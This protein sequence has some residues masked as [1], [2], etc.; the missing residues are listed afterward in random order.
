MVGLLNKAMYGLRDAPQVWQQE[1]R[2]IMSELD[3][4]ESKT[5]PCVYFNA[6][7]GVRVVTHVD[8]F[9]CVGP[10]I[11]LQ[12]FYSE[13]DKV[14]DLKCEILGPGPGEGKEGQFLGRQ[15]RWNDWGLSWR[16]DNK[17][18]GEML[19][20]WGMEEC[21]IVGT[22]CSK[23]EGAKPREEGDVVMEDQGRITR[24]RRAAAK[25]NY[26]ALDDPRI[27]YASKCISQCMAKPTEEG[28]GRLKRV[29]RYLSGSPGCEWKFEWQ[30]RPTHLV[31]YTDSDWAGCPRTRRSTSGGG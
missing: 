24:F 21:S 20:E 14:L 17:L 10:K 4:C 2:R 18:L 16:G 3:F 9:L 27:S 19:K 6:R 26:M 31:G 12:H 8:D 1:V 25:I 11:G 15:I 13:L 22:P 5:S 28:E 29:L 30:E 7:S 23:E